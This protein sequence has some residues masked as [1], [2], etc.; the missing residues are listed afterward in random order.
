[1]QKL[2]YDEERG[3][4]YINSEQYFEKIE[5][6]VWEYLIGSY[7]VLSKW[8]KYRKGRKLSLKEIKHYLNVITVIKRTIQ[9][10]VLIDELYPEV[11][12]HIVAFKD[13]QPVSRL[14]KFNK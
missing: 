9:L 7:Q 12:K 1:M 10:Q 8:L 3:R 2:F 5:N 14:E 4:I 13:G 11:E 6:N